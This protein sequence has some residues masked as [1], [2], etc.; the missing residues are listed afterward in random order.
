MCSNVQDP[1]KAQ[2]SVHSEYPPSIAVDRISSNG[3]NTTC[4]S[5]T[6]PTAHSK[7]DLPPLSRVIMGR[8]N[9]KGAREQ[10]M[11]DSKSEVSEMSNTRT[12]LVLES[13]TLRFRKK[14]TDFHFGRFLKF[15]F[16]HLGYRN[17]PPPKA[18]LDEAE[19]IPEANA[20]WVSLLTL[21]WIGPIL[22]LGYSHPL[23]A[24]DLY[25]LQDDRSSSVIAEKILCSFEERQKKAVEYNSRLATGE[26]SPGLKGIWWSIRGQREEREREW[27]AKSGKKRASLT[28]AVNDSVFWLFWSGG[29]LRL[30]SCIA[31]ATSPLAIKVISTALPP[32]KSYTLTRPSFG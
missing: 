12:R 28:L 14:N 19:I 11:V 18:S 29:I 16:L 3:P 20:S 15:D 31:S 10:P 30:I 8:D 27:R 13:Q 25:K 21:G 26:I 1:Q 5:S 2:A 6:L 22:R 7:V 17:P 23:E 32:S 9:T 4:P 24:T